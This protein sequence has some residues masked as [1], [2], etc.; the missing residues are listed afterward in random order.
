MNI[1]SIDIGGTGLKAAIVDAQGNLLTQRVRVGTPHPS[2]PDVIV[3]ALVNLV[4]QLSDYEGVSVG[5]PG[6]VRQGRVITAPKLGN[7]VWKDFDLAGA[8]ASRLGKPAHVLNDADMQ[9]LAAIK[10]K[11][12]EMVITLGTGFGSALFMDGQLGP[13]LELSQHIF[14]KGETYNE[15]L[16]NETL[17]RIGKRKWNRRVRRAI[18]ALRV[19]TNFDMLYIG[20]GNAEKIEFELP[21]DAKIISNEDGLKGG[22]WLWHGRSAND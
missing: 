19:L 4:A 11:G 6:V 13:H 2:P 5:F 15:Q 17:H 14:R 12:V 8:L 9:G 16:G 3:D 22:A 18:D 21:V 7:E 10:G 20:G 1:L